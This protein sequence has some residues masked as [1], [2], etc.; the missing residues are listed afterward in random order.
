MTTN[1]SKASYALL[2]PETPEKIPLVF[3]SPHSGLE[4]PADFQYAVT[5]DELKTGWDAFIDE[6]WSP[7]T[8][9]GAY[10]LSAKTS[11]MYI[12]LNRAP[13]DIDPA[14]LNEPWPEPLQPTK[15][16]E[17]GMGLIRRF[18]LPGLAINKKPLSVAEIQHRIKHYYQP[19]HQQLAQLLSSLH[20][21]YGG[22]WHIDCHSMKSRG[23]AMNI[24]QNQTRPDIILGN[25]DGTSASPEFT[26]VIQQAFAD[27]GYSVVLNTPYKGGYLTQCFANPA[28]NKHSIQIEINRELYMDEKEFSKNEK[29]SAFQSDLTK[30]SACIANFVKSKL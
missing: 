25:L 15:Y 29:F 22:V 4:L 27:L 13:T 24:D 26:E 10:L 7:A 28:E 18:A 6:L 2:N 30:V 17:R 20:Q 21:A 19:Y 5:I 11:R 3:D 8:T 23:N 1:P 14:L 12:D 9:F 16:T